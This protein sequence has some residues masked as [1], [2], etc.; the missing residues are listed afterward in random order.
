MQRIAQVTFDIANAVEQLADLK[1]A[2]CD[3]LPNNIGCQ[4]DGR[5][6]LYDN[7]AAE[8]SSLRVGPVTGIMKSVPDPSS[9]ALICRCVKSAQ[10]Q[11]WLT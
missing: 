2:H 11:I 5:G 9:C 1:I 8:V 6:C 4:D 3:I 10:M 7:D